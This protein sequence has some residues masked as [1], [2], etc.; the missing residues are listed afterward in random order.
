MEKRGQ[1]ELSF[2]MIFTIIVIIVTVAVASY[3]IIK[4]LNVN[5]CQEIGTFYTELEKEATKALNAGMYSGE[6]TAKLNGFNGRI[7]AICFGNMSQSTST[8]ADELMKRDLGELAN[9][10]ENVFIY[11]AS[12][13][14]DAKFRAKKMPYIKTDGFFCVGLVKGIAKVGMSIT[15]DDVQVKLSKI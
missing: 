8:K 1:M 15:Q 13:A 14:C 6:F 12:E 11:P 3:I 2:S 4:F 5:K 9:P 7:K 10:G